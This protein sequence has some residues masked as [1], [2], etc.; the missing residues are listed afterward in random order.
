MFSMKTRH[1]ESYWATLKKQISPETQQQLQTKEFIRYS[2]P[3]CSTGFVCY[4]FTD[5]S[6]Y[7]F[8]QMLI[9]QPTGLAYLCIEYLRV[10]SQN[11]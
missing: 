4:V 6:F 2:Q 11:G 7:H 3:K 5:V 9:R 1:L 8:V 10:M